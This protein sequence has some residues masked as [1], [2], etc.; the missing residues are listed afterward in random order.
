MT[1]TESKRPAEAPE[2]NKPRR[3]KIIL[4]TYKAGLLNQYITSFIKI[5]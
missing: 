2:E 4:Y 1:E 3:R 5:L